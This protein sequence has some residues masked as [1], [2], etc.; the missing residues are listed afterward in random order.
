M[1]LG[2][3]TTGVLV[4]GGASGIGRATALALAEVGRPV[5]VWDVDAEGA[6]SCARECRQ[7][8]G[9]AEFAAVD[10]R[11]T[12]AVPGAV[13]KAESALGS[14]GGFVHAAGVAGAMTVDVLDEPVWEA[15]IGVNLTAAVMITKA[16][17]GPLGR[18]GPGSAVVLVSSIEG[19]FGSAILPAYCASKS[20]VIGVMR[21]IAH[22]L[23]SS[24]VRANAVCPGAVDTPML[25][26]ALALPGF[27]DQL[28][29]RTPMG[30]LAEPDEIA[31]P[32]RFL[33]S[34]EASFVTGTCLTV[35]GGLTAI[36]AI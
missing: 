23:G 18:A 31:R 14:I 22:H 11:D 2:H 9:V 13:E 6:E 35:D 19:H 15:T 30:R 1:S 20:G 29:A 10:V 28:E 36:T 24:G 32:V 21:S 16:L 33:L 17:L 34:E 12:A 7:R 4:T 25:A 27:R 8:G 5:M 3:P 26:P